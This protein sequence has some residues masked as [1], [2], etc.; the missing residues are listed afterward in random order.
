MSRYLDPKADV[1]FKKI[2]GDHPHLLMS[3]LNAVL[4]LP[5]DSPIV[6]LTYL[7]SEQVPA[8]PEFKRTI[9]D[10]KCKDAKGRAFVVEMQM[11][12][13]DSFKQRL[14]FGAS[15]A[16][17]KQLDKGKDYV[18]LQP[19]YGL[20][21]VAEIYDTL[22]PDWYHHYQLVKKGS[23]DGD[24]IDHLQLIFIELPKFPVHSAE[25]KTL[26]LLW[27]RFLR[28]IDEKT[29]TVSH[30]LLEVPEIAEAV[31]LAEES[32]YTQA[33]LAFYESYWDQVRREKTLM[34]EKYTK[35]LAA[36]KAEGKAEG[37]VE[38]LAAG[39][40]RGKAEGKVEGKME[41]A[42]KML[43]LNFSVATIVE[44]TEL[45]EEEIECLK[46]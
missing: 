29:K 25:E 22:S 41:I 13:T 8:I 40:A 16:F 33:E 21:L 19:V 10:A 39:E 3:F 17:V 9:A 35:G 24:I 14:L 20:G 18:L 1:V 4:P 15:Q 31:E 12:W 43:T 23:Q 28:E 30:E 44:A 38:G 46:E 32:A 34:S 26:R 42:R 45:T 7:P 27:L 11:N 6:E 2:F 5:V 37:L 36:G